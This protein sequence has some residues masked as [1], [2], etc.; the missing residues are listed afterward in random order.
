VDVKPLVSLRFPLSE[1]QT[2]AIVHE[3]LIDFGSN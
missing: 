2:V 1:H 3:R